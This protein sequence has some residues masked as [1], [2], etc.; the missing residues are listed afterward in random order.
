MRNRRV[1]QR[2]LLHY[3]N[4]LYKKYK[5][6]VSLNALLRRTPTAVAATVPRSG[7][8]AVVDDIDAFLERVEGGSNV[9]PVSA[10]FPN[11]HMMS[12]T[13][14][15]S[16]AHSRHRSVSWSPM[17]VPGCRGRHSSNYNDYNSSP[18]PDARKR[19]RSPSPRRHRRSS[20][21]GHASPVAALNDAKESD[22]EEWLQAD[23]TRTPEA[24]GPAPEVRHTVVSDAPLRLPHLNLCALLNGPTVSSP[25]CVSLL[26]DSGSHIVLI[27]DDLAAHLGLR[28]FKLPRPE[29]I[30][31]TTTDSSSPMSTTTLHEFVKLRITDHSNTWTSHT[32]QAIVSPSLCSP[33]IL[34][35]PFLS[36]NKLAL[37][38]EN[39]TCIDKVS[40][41]DILNTKESA[42]RLAS[43]CRVPDRRSPKQKRVDYFH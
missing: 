26:L 38:C 22:D 34:G 31:V 5:A 25:L 42:E 29:V 43:A 39:H 7:S 30:G 35:L 12:D 11:A 20:S 18:S 40:G 41:I 9:N 33:M 23:G 4:K 2:A 19:R 24:A 6:R 27:R 36:H 28:R 17:H 32:V 1:G 37:D 21:L 13:D 3:A 8:N 15:Y 16:N 14:L 10:V